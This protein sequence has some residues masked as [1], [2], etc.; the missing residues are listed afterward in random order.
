MKVDYSYIKTFLNVINDKSNFE[1][2]NNNMGF[3]TIC[4]HA[5]KTGNEFG[6]EDVD[7]AIEGISDEAYGLRNLLNNIDRIEILY[8]ELVSKEK[9]WLSEVESYIAKLFNIND[10]LVTT[11]YPVIGYDIGIG[12]DKKVCVN[13]NSEICLN[14]IKELISI[15]IHETAHTFFEEIHGSIFETHCSKTLSDMKNFLHNAIQYEGVGIFSA[16]DYR[17]KNNLPNEGSVIQED[18]LIASCNKRRKDIRNEYK[19]LLNDLNTGRINSSQE[20]LTRTF[21]KSKLAHRLGYSI[22]TEIN[23]TSGIEGVREAIRIPNSEF[24]AKYLENNLN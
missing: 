13:L 4:L 2:L 3:Q 15:I 16:E 17:N 20:F 12:L 9:E 11:I 14:N 24:A 5:K 1:K 8:R 22:F 7:R 18:Y 10:H 19:R 21:G 6:I 23:Q